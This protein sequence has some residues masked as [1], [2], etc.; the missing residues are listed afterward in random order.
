MLEST[1]SSS[2]I[3]KPSHMHPYS[4]LLQLAKCSSE[5]VA[6]DHSLSLETRSTKSVCPPNHEKFPEMEHISSKIF[7][8]YNAKYLLEMACGNIPS[9]TSTLSSLQLGSNKKY[10]FQFG[11]SIIKRDDK[12]ESEDAI[13]AS[14]YAIGLADGVGGWNDYGISSADF[15]KTLM[16]KCK[17][18]FIDHESS[19]EDDIDPIRVLSQAFNSINVFGSSTA[20]LCSSENGHLT[21]SNIGDSGFL[22]VKFM[23][24][25]PF[26][27]Q[28][29]TPQQHDFNV[30]FQLSK[31]PSMEYIQSLSD[32]GDYISKKLYSKLSDSIFCQDLP[33]QSDYYQINSLS[34]GDLIILASDG[35][36]DNLYDSEILSLISKN[37]SKNGSI[38]PNKLSESITKLAYEKSKQQTGT[39]SP[40]NDK[41]EETSDIVCDAGK[42]DD[43]SVI[44]G[45][46]GW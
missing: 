18:I 42:E 19:L 28:K 44:V 13:F 3:P 21:C 39:R 38:N 24:E 40:F 9:P 20:V 15:A 22:H 7:C 30:P 10:K 17:A 43:I 27:V 2:S 6:L 12:L 14:D 37:Y 25:K 46:L 11:S 26:I 41:L 32:K 35:V 1:T 31:I 29:S 34:K 33:S 36:L 4:E 8:S 45:V 23:N 16:S 5:Y